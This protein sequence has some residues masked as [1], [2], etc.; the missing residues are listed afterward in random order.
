MVCCHDCFHFQ[1]R[2]TS[3]IVAELALLRASS[4]SALVFIA[5]GGRI[6]TTVDAIVVEVCFH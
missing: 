1:G 5:K 4:I 6:A 3:S 2:L